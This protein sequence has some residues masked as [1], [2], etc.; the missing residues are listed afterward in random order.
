MVPRWRNMVPNSAD[1]AA[2]VL[3]CLQRPAVPCRVFLLWMSLYL[4]LDNSIWLLT[5]CK[6]R[7]YRWW[8]IKSQSSPE[9]VK[10]HSVKTWHSNSREDY[11]T[12][13]QRRDPSLHVLAHV[14]KKTDLLLLLFLLR[15]AKTSESQVKLKLQRNWK[16]QDGVTREWV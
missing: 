14:A 3:I 12:Q 2:S 16:G 8:R 11:L 9:V 10:I 6:S 5:K 4:T 13:N 1:S 7:T 15:A